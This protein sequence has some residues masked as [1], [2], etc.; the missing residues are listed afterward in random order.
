MAGKAT[1]KDPSFDKILERIRS[2]R[3]FDFRN[4]KRETLQR[5]IARRMGERKSPN[6]ID[7]LKILEREPEEFSA[8]I[9][10][11]LIKVTSFFRDP[12]A[13]AELAKRIL[14]RM[15]EGRKPGSEIRI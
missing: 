6:Y 13:W 11:M 10:T 3:N 2:V 9:S 8:L 5:R 14:P 15:L 7:Y 4:Y 12:E 1:S